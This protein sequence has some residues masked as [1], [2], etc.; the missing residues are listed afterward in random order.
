MRTAK[1]AGT[2]SGPLTPLIFVAL[3]AI[4]LIISAPTHPSCGAA[5]VAS[6]GSFRGRVRW[7]WRVARMTVRRR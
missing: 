6:C 7:S 5:G 3:S 4:S 2:I 1:V